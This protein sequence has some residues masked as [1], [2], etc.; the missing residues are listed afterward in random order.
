[1]LILANHGLVV[2]E[3]PKTG[4]LALRAMLAPYTAPQSDTAPRHTNHGRFLRN[5]GALLQGRGTPPQTVAVI[6]DPVERMQSWYRYR[7]RPRLRGLPAS[8]HEVSFEDFIR[9][10]LDGTHRQMANVGRQDRFVAWDGMRA[11]VD[12]VF[13]YARLPLLEAFFSSRIGAALTLPE[14][15][16]TPA[17]VQAD[18]TLTP[19]T[20]AEFQTRNMEEIVLYHEVARSGYLQR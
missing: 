19:A 14:R 18:Y 2:L 10:Y 1:M 5:Y 6:R 11:G 17:G 15:N 7:R 8:T 9:A 3:V 12:H 13:D 4:S 20:L 16:K